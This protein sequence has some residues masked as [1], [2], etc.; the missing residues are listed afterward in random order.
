MR[1]LWSTLALVL[2]LAGLG[3]YIYFV[4]WKKTEGD[5]NR[6]EKVFASFAN[7]KL[8]EI[9]V[10]STSGDTTTLKKQNGVWQVTSPITARADDSQVIAIA[11]RLASVEIA[12]VIDENPTDLKDYGL[13]EPRIEVDFKDAN[14]KD[15]RKL[16]IGEKTPTGIDLFA[17]RNDEKRVFL[18]PSYEETAL[19]VG[20]F[21]LR[22]KTILQF[23]H[24]KVDGVELT[25][26][27]KTFE[28][29]KEN[30]E[31]K[32]K[33]PL[34][35]KADQ[36]AVE[37]LLSRLQTSQMKTIV[38]SDA[39]PADL[40]KYGLDK[41]AVTVNVN[42]G[43]SRATLAIGAKTSENTYYARDVSRPAVVT[44][45]A[46]LV[47]GLERGADQYRRKDIFEFRPYNA[48][49][50]EI[51]REGQTAVFDQTK[52]TPENPL[53]TWKR[54]SPNP[55]EP[56]KNKFDDFLSKLSNMRAIAYAEVKTKTGLEHPAMTVAVKFSEKEEHVSFGKADSDVYAAVAGEPTAAQASAADYAEMVKALDAVAK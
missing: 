54:V 55:G 51:T 33:K 40:K 15:Y 43:S 56:D 2:V 27:G 46:P 31:W 8:D 48:T 12:R 16:L 21:Q 41:P 45:D 37:E 39:K 32:L 11:G 4:T 14:D 3:A 35:V 1:R 6:K 23:D 20:T 10:K 17:K 42:S 18:I 44:V 22:D 52:G 28:I 38:T 19:N 34:Q 29:G 30:G 9:R 36:S 5:A 13:A 49:H 25:A 26:S 50:L 47:D 53:G 7:D 24:D